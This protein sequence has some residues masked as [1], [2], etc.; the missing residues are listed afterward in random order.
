M[1][2]LI[3]RLVNLRLFQGDLDLHLVRASMVIL[4]FFFGYQKWFD[5]E[6]QGLIPF[7][8]HGPL[9]FWMHSVFGIKGSSYFLGVS[10]WLLGIAAA[11]RTLEQKAGNPGF[12]RICGHVHQ[13]LTTARSHPESGLHGLRHALLTEPGEHTDPFTLQYVAG[14]DTI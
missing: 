2:W 5:Y 7:F 10:E 11:A 14:H 3:N 6:A 8:T 13:Q 1:N 4:Y 9:I 12:A